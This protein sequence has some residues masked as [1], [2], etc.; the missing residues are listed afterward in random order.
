[1][2]RKVIA[3]AVLALVATSG[4]IAAAPAQANP[5]PSG[6]EV[7]AAPRYVNLSPTDFCPDGYF[8][9][10]ESTGLFGSGVGFLDTELNWG[11]IPTQFRWINNFAKSG[12][13]LG[14]PGRLQDVKVYPHP[15]FRD[16]SA[17]P[18]VCIDNSSFRSSWGR[19]LPESNRW[20]DNC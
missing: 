6:A 17:F 1:M 20:F 11:T 7:A 12:Q 4:V 8:C 19:L 13:N 18:A 3:G 10:Y 15:G 5:A 16:D 2:L 14:F 9:A